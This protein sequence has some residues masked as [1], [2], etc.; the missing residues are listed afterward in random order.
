[1]AVAALGAVVTQH[2]TDNLAAAVPI[3]EHP[4]FQ[5]K[6]TCFLDH[7]GAKP[8]SNNPGK[9]NENGSVEKSNDLFKSALD[10]R[11][12]LRGNR[13]FKTVQA[14]EEYLHEMVRE[15]NRTRRERLEEEQPLLLPLPQKGWN[16]PRQTSASVTAWST[17]RVGSATY[18]VPSRFIGVKLTAL[19][20]F[21]RIE[22]FYGRHEILKVSKQQP[23]GKSIN[24]RHLIFHL[25]R[26]PGAFRNY[27]FRD[28][29]FPRI[30]F[31]QAYDKLL[32]VNDE[33][34]DKEYLHIL[35]QAASGSENDVATALQIL[36]DQNEVPTTEQVK[37]LCGA[38]SPKVPTVN[39]LQPSLAKYDN[40]LSFHKTEK[41]S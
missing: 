33:T 8:S 9:S 28:E 24:Y 10:Q 13:D 3:G 21:D 15:R 19:E 22:V 4:K 1:M 34:A 2:R 23:G 31:R 18:S 37:Q 35:H 20:Y 26:K 36:L 38:V 41:R 11:L 16:E 14:Y 40:L 29:L 17:V 39:V 12:L 5:V 27:Q 32:S 30:V 6:W 7:Y 25:M